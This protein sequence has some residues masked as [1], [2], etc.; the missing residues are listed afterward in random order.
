MR[1]VALF[2]LLLTALTEGRSFGQSSK[3]LRV[4][5]HQEQFEMRGKVTQERQRDCIHHNRYCIYEPGLVHV[6]H[7]K[8]YDTFTCEKCCSGYFTRR[9]PIPGTGVCRA[10][11]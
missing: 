6:V 4:E 5:T 9:T 11:P 2:L 3:D 10:K 1:V 7:D 8:Y